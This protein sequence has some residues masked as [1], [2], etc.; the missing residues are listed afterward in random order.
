MSD[1]QNIEIERYHDQITEDV[2]QLVERYREIMAWDVPDNDTVEADRLIF[3][4]IHAA[5]VE[6]ETSSI[7]V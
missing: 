4:A 1:I 6:I 2:R 5:V 7:K 3:Q